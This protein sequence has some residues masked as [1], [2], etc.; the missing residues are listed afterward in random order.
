MRDCLKF[1]NSLPLSLQVQLGMLHGFLVNDIVKEKIKRSHMG[2]PPP[3][4]HLYSQLGY[5]G[6]L[7]VHCRIMPLVFCKVSQ[8][9]IW[10]YL[11]TRGNLRQSVSLK[12]TAEARPGS[13]TFRST[14]Y[15]DHQTNG[16][17]G[18]GTGQIGH[19]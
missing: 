9:V 16:Y 1:Q 13:P 3:P 5:N 7:L 14:S 12:E 4:P 19:L 8:M 15:C 6:S 11:Y 18:L 2:A 17:A 10:C